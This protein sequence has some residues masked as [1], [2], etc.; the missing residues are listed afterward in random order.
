MNSVSNETLVRFQA[1]RAWITL[2]RP[3]YTSA[4]WGLRVVYTDTVPT[5][6]VDQYGRLYVSPAF[7]D[8]IWTNAP[9]ETDATAQLA[10]VLIHEL[11]HVL[12]DHPTRRTSIDARPDLWNLAADA[13]IN[14]DLQR[15]GLLLPS[16][17]IF[18]KTID[19]PENEIAEAYYA[20]LLDRESKNSSSNNYS[21]SSSSGS[22][23]SGSSSSGSSSS[24]SSSSGSSSSSS[25][26]GDETG[27]GDDANGTSGE[28]DQRKKAKNKGPNTQ[29]GTDS[30]SSSDGSSGAEGEPGSGDS[31]SGANGESDQRKK[32]K[33]KIPQAQC[34]SGAGGEP[35]SWELDGEAEAERLTP[36]DL[37]SLRRKFAKDVLDHVKSHGRGTVPASLVRLA[38]ELAD[39]QVSW[40]QEL[41]TSLRGRV[42]LLGGKTDW[43]WLRPSRRSEA[44]GNFILPGMIGRQVR[45]GVIVD[46]SG[47]MGSD[48]LAQARAELVGVLRTSQADVWVVSCD[49]EATEPRHLTHIDNLELVGGGG[50]DLR[51]GFNALEPIRPEIIVALTDGYTP[52]PSNAPD[53]EVIVVLIGNDDVSS[54]PEWAH[55]IPVS[56]AD[57]HLLKRA[58]VV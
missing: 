45:V 23:S 36:G 7:I 33:N 11:H 56:T 51:E 39:P 18:P 44:A 4:L 30:G 15:D 48:E 22:S 16:N 17:G 43:S 24:G 37:D 32:A 14:D 21:G 47:S 31:A 10:A 55:T 12:R 29:C 28:G 50:T 57:S 13:E 34:G 42:S 40:Q 9:N 35:G 49:A 3:Y 2:N 52:W 6:G 20:H 53:A 1:A 27:S 26:A 46:T 19:A 8:T 41:Q 54:T 58:P 25:G 5:A 38:E